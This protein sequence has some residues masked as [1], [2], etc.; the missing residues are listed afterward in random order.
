MILS[1]IGY[2]RTLE[3]RELCDKYSQ[4]KNKLKQDKNKKEG[5][6]ILNK[7]FYDELFEDY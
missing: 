3:N 1:K 7:E 5:K 4:L 2:S 6:F